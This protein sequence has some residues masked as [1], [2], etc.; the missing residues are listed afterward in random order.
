MVVIATVAQP[1]P[2]VL[3]TREPRLAPEYFPALTGLRFFL[4]LWVILHHL[5][6]KG[7]MLEIWT[8]SLPTAVGVFF[9]QGHVA[10]RTFFV[11]S[12]FVLTQGYAHSRWKRR[13]LIAYGVAR[14]ARVYPVYLVSLAVVSYFILE[15]LMSP[16]FSVAGKAETFGAYLLVLQGWMQ[17]PG[18]GW[19]TPAWSLSCEFVFYLCLPALLIWLGKRDRWRLA[20]LVGVGLVWT[21]VLKSAGVPF[22]WKPILHLGDFLVGIATARIYGIMKRSGTSRRRGSWFYLPAIAAG[23]LLVM[24]PDSLPRIID[25]GTALRPLNGLLVL[26]L[27]LGGGPVARFLGGAVTQ[28]LGQA[29]YSMYILHV[30]LLWWFGN[31]G[32]T[33]LPWM[34]SWAALVYIAAIILISAACFEWI[35]KPANRSIRRWAAAKLER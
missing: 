14:F 17:S 11:L 19:N 25:L 24:Y 12:G 35:E 22:T 32:P 20:V 8:Q 33:L 21:M 5:V 18:A 29:S 2:A 30:P 7:M 28:Y 27:A 1:A 4:A 6:S 31:R 23:I 16:E 15:F 34:A 3:I 13:D 9:E 10:V 26:G